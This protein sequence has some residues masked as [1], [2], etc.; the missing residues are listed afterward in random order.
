MFLKTNV[1]PLFRWIQPFE[2]TL[3]LLF[4]LKLYTIFLANQNQQLQNP[5]VVWGDR[6][7]ADL[8]NDDSENLEKDE[9]RDLELLQRIADALVE[10]YGLGEVPLL[11]MVSQVKDL[12]NDFAW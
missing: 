4:F 12:P 9:R 10:F 7:L 2:F 11:S 6:L 5:A 8:S 1:F 3:T